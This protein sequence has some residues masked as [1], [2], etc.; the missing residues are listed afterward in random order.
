MKTL[1]VYDNTGKIWVQMS[2]SYAIPE[3]LP[4]LEVDVPEGKYISHV[5]VSGAEPVVVYAEAPVNPIQ[6][7][8]DETAATVEMLLTELI[9]SLME[10]INIP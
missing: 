2:G 10:L 1:I 3:G 6:V 5:D 4:Y 7:Q 9:P 8:L